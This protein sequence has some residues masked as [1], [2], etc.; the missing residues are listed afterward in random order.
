MWQHP[1]RHVIVDCRER[2]AVIGTPIAEH[3]SDRLVSGCLAFVGDAAHAP[4]SMTG[5]GCSMSLEDAEAI[6]ASF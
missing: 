2:R 1:W 4:T 3:V 5:S 6:A